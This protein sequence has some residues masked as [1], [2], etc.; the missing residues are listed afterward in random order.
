MSANAPRLAAATHV[1][2]LHATVLVF[3]AISA[4]IAIFATGVGPQEALTVAIIASPGH[5]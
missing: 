5:P 2:N 4:E 1:A 3:P